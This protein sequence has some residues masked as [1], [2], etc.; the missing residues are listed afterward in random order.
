[1][2]CSPSDET[3]TKP[4][5]GV[6]LMVQDDLVNLIPTEIITEGF[7]HFYLQG[8]A[9]KYICD[10]GW[11]EHICILVCCGKSGCGQDVKN[12]TEALAKAVK[13]E[14]EELAIPTFIVGDFNE[15]PDTI[16]NFGDMFD[17][18]WTDIG[19]RANWWGKQPRL[20][21]CWSKEGAKPSR[22]DG[23]I[24][25][26]KGI[27]FIDDFDVTK[28]IKVPTHA[29][30]KITISRNAMQEERTYLRTMG[31]LKR[32]FEQRMEE[33]TEEIEDKKQTNEIRKKEIEAMKAN[34][35]DDIEEAGERLRTMAKQ[36][37]TTASGRYGQM[38]SRTA[39]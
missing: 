17:E 28:D 37:N 21:T 16:V 26:L 32:P 27:G 15:E 39:P 4:S 11:E 24:T 12:V 1:M 29:F 14:Q 25:N 13:E 9:G 10:L 22:I 3:S 19:A 36:K 7:K 33:L 5:A 35:D 2:E 34:M 8:R 20:P 31:N 30:V 23:I 6:G 18:G 38:S